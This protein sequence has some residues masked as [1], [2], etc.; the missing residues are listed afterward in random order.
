MISKNYIPIYA[1]RFMAFYFIIVNTIAIYLFPGGSLYNYEL[2][3]YSFTEN[4]FSDLGVYETSG[5]HENFLSCILFNSTLAMIGFASFSYIYVPS[6]FSSNKKAYIYSVVA[7]VILILSGICYIGVALTPADLYFSEHVWFVIFAFHLQ[8]IGILFMVI[9]FFLSPANNKY[10]IVAFIYF[11]C[12][13]AYSIFETSSPPPPDFDPRNQE[14]FKEFITYDRMV[15]SVV[16]QKLITLI[17]FIS[18]I[19]FTF[20]FKSLIDQETK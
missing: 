10:T 8:T 18:T 14:M 20:G 16:S 12:V 5:G 7:T 11:I 13:A 1:L 2:T 17:A 19:I 4:F 6:I 9:A 3:S 15:I